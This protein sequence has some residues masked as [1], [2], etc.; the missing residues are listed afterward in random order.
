[1]K[2]LK[3]SPVAPAMMMFGGSPIR[4]A[5]P[6]M[7]DAITSMISSGTASMSS[8]SASRKVIGAISRIVVRLS[9][10]AE[11]RAVIAG[12]AHR[13]REGAPA[14]ELA[15]ADRDVVV[16]PGLLGQVDEDHHPDQQADRVEV[17]R[18]DRLLLGEVADEEDDDRGAEQGDVGAV[19]LLAGD[20]RQ[21]DQEG[22]YGDCQWGLSGS[23]T[24][25]ADQSSRLTASHSSGS[26]CGDESAVLHGDTADRKNGGAPQGAAAQVRQRLVRLRERV[27]RDLGAHRNDGRQLEE[28]LAVA[29]GSGWRPS[30]ACAPP[31][32]AR[33]GRRGSRS[34]GCRR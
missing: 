14:G 23:A 32:G 29:R 7:F 22:G 24:S 33:R 34:C 31:R 21:G 8:A 18:L 16:D 30:R 12:Q 9:R 6:P 4:V 1:M 3:L 20:D 26:A 25:I 27:G 10:K 2:A 13:H 17:D 19:Q 5:V 11:S 28:L 15:G